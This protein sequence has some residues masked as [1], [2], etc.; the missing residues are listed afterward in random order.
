MLD[1]DF[2]RNNQ[3]IVK[4]AATDKGSKVDIDQLLKIDGDYRNFLQQAEGLRARRN[5][6][7]HAGKNSKPTDEQIFEG[8]ELKDK[9]SSVE[10]KTRSLLE[11]RNDLMY[12]IPNIPS[13]D[14]PIGLSEDDNLVVRQVG[15]KTVFDFKPKPHWELT[16]FI[17]QETATNNASAR[18]AYLKGGLVQLQMALAW[19]GMQLLTDQMIIEKIVNDNGLDVSTK[20]FEPIYPPLMLN[21][22]TYKATGRLKPDEVTFKLNNDDL[23]LIGSAEHSL[24]PYYRNKT[25]SIDDLPVRFAGYTTAFRREV[26]SAG[27]D[28]RGITR[29]HHFQKLEMESFT[30]AKT[31]RAEHDFMIAIQEYITQQLELPYQVILK[32]TGDMGGPNIRGVDIETWMPGQ[33]RYCETHSADYMGD[34]QTRD[35]KTKVKTKDGKQLAHTNDATAIADRTLIAIMENYQN[36]DGSIRVPKVLQT[37]LK[38]EVIS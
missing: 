13:D 29:V 38:K 15:D 35:L 2:V 30:D 9:L 12:S 34:Y 26:G 16:R 7:A 1:I 28:T 23:W 18:F 32:A 6:L 3:E 33:D 24:V 14:T 10:D 5:E 11:Q 31:S 22:E 17:D 20:P 21:T 8:R 27:K 25:L 37:Y 36:Q 4:K 19:W